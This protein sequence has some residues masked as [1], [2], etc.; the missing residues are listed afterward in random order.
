M[1]SITNAS[2]VATI[3]FMIADK[4]FQPQKTVKLYAQKFDKCKF[5]SDSAFFGSCFE[6]FLFSHGK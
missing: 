2:T 4:A 5:V 1:Q 3:D 6:A